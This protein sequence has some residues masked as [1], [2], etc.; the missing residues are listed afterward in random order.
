MWVKVVNI[1]LNLAV[2]IAVPITIIYFSTFKYFLLWFKLKL[3]WSLTSKPRELDR[4]RPCFYAYWYFEEIIGTKLGSCFIAILLTFDF[5][6]FLASKWGNQNQPKV[7]EENFKRPEPLRPHSLAHQ[8]L[9][10]V[11]ETGLFIELSCLLP[12]V[13][14]QD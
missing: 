13:G 10:Q 5:P 7:K 4:F 3:I 12:V 11:L 9:L 2:P 8:L 14:S 6:F 1:K